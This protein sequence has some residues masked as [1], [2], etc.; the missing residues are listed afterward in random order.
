[1]Q[2][3]FEFDY[4]LEMYK[5]KAKRRWGYYAL[6]ILHGDQLLGKIDAAAD[7]AN[8]EL[9]VNAIHED[10]PFAPDVT[11]GVR[12]ELTDLARWLGLELV[13]PG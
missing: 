10:A 11:E 3:L 12:A 8:G 4:T 9:V 7:R 1:M 13:L 2:D 5:P 6:P